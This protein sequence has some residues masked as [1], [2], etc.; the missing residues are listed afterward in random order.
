MART[1]GLLDFFTCSEEAEVN[2]SSDS[3]SR[4]GGPAKLV[5]KLKG[6]EDQVDPYST[7]EG[8]DD[9]SVHISSAQRADNVNG[10]YCLMCTE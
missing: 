8:G 7:A 9:V 6:Q 4:D 1:E 2:E 3:R 5:D 10:T